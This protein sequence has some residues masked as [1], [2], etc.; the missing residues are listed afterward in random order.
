MRRPIAIPPTILHHPVR[1]GRPAH[2][3]NGTLQP[4]QHHFNILV[5]MVLKEMIIMFDQDDYEISF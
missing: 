1:L 5:T 4:Q 2:P 3:L